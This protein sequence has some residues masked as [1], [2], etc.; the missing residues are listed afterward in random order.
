MKITQSFKVSKPLPVVWDL[1]QNIPEVAGCMPGAQLSEDKG[2]GTYAGRLNAK[3]G[4]FN[5]HFDG[6][7][8]VTQ[9]AADRSGHVEGK[10][11]DKRG[12]SRTKLV[13]D[14]RLTEAAGATQVTIDADLQL[15]GPIAQ[16]GRTGVINETAAILI[17][18]FV[19]NVET[20][21][22]AIHVDPAAAT[23]AAPA[24]PRAESLNGMALMWLLFKSFFSRLLGRAQT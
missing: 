23:G 7:A 9:N 13:L 11:T 19:R 16:F 8:Q 21:L 17:G 3:L 1:F 18:Q 6:E 15:S 14:Y 22:A 24:A 5:A 4:P 2:D 12:G 10:G 20:K